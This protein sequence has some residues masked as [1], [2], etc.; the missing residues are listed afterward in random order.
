MNQITLRSRKVGYLLLFVFSLSVCACKLQLVSAYDDK[1]HTQITTATTDIDSFYTLMIATSAPGSTG[2]SFSNYAVGYANIE[3]E[4]RSLYNINS[5][6]SKN[7]KQDSICKIALNQWIKYE[8]MHK[9]A[10]KLND[11][12]IKINRGIMLA[13]M[14]AMEIS[15]RVKT[16]GES[17]TN[18][19]PTNP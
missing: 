12:Q 19:T 7:A 16:L 6:R 1:I 17:Q 10:D 14:Q 3:V 15:E 11:V 2:R 4:L 8:D 13:Q 9:T 5:T 18:T